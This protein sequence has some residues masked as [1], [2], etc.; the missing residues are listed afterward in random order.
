M[1]TAPE[2]GNNHQ[3]VP[4]PIHSVR[5]GHL[6]VSWPLGEPVIYSAL[7]LQELPVLGRFRVFPFVLVI[8]TAIFNP[9]NNIKKRKVGKREISIKHD[10]S[11]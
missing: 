9:A 1:A 11:K 3:H 5:K 4:Q 2:G 7:E 8:F 6:L 10:M